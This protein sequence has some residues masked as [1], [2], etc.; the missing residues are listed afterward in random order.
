MTYLRTYQRLRRAVSGEIGDPDMFPQRDRALQIS[1]PRP[2]LCHEARIEGDLV[3]GLL[4]EGI[5][6]VLPTQ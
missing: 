1:E 2:V 3:Y 6:V 5:G 4:A